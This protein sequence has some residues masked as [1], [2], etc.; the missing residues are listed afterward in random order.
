MQ[1]KQK[2]DGSTS[3]RC[4]ESFKKVDQFGQTVNLTWNGEDEYKTTLGASVS[5]VLI[6][7][8][9]IYSAYRV[10]YL[11]NRYNPT[12]SK[13]TL[14]RGPEDDLPFKPQE[15]GFDFAF[16]LERKLDPDYGFF[17]LR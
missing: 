1:L 9:L 5:S 2:K 16:G 8:L 15:Y 11:V 7:I 10:F 12:V 6:V 13:T 3:K 14:I 4:R 17:T